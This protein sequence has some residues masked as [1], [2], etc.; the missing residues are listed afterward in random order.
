MDW[1][2][3]GKV[4]MVAG[5][6]KGLGFAVARALALAGADI[7]MV[8]RDAP[9][10]T[11]A[12]SDIEQETKARV[13]ALP[14]DLR[15]A[16][17]MLQWR[18]R[19]LERFGRVDILFTNTGGPPTGGF[20]DFDDNAWRDAFEL[21]VLSVVRMV[22]LVVPEMKSQGGGSIA[23]ATSALVKE[24][25]TEMILS[26]VLRASVA[27]LAK[28]LA[29]EFARDGIR[30]NHIIPGRIDMGRIRQLDE[31]NASRAG[32][33]SSAWRKQ[34]SASIPLGRYG[35]PDEFAQAVLFLSSNAAS[36]ITG[37]TL[38]V[39]GAKSDAQHDPGEAY[40]IILCNS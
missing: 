10:I 33:T 4:A 18:D 30:V 16:A 38:Q 12:A 20:F 19:T 32:I 37:A 34:I 31:L 28:A 23:V 6:S 40:R 7:S 5:A 2:L 11:Q 17:A 22:R 39:D 26:T 36:Y 15:S 1:G 3:H 8:S 13:L 25:S 35:T 9:S 14:V 24:S 21:L 27:S 29:I